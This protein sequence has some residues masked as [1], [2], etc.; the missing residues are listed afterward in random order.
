LILGLDHDLVGPEEA[1][2]P[3][4]LSVDLRARVVAAWEGGQIRVSFDRSDC[5]RYFATVLRP[6]P[7]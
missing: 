6:T 3:G 7:S 1:L 4:A 5:C 2:M